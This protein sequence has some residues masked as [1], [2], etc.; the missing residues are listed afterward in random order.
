M[1]YLLTNKICLNKINQEGTST[2][3]S[4][5]QLKKGYSSSKQEFWDLLK[6]LYAHYHAYQICVVAERHTIFSTV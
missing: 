5:L 6:K 1:T 4:T 3:L 2:W